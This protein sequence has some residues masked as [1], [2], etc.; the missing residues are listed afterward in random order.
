MP[1]TFRTTRPEPMKRPYEGWDQF[2]EMVKTRLLDNGVDWFWTDE[3][4]GG[5]EPRF[6]HNLYT[7]MKEVQEAYDNRRS[8]NCARGG[9]SGCQR[10]GYPWMGDVHYDRKMMIANLCNG[11]SG[12]PHSTHD[13]SGASLNNLKEETYLNGVKCNLFNPLSQCNAWVRWN[14]KSHRPWDWSPEAEQVF[15]KFLDLHYQLVPYYYTT[16]WQSHQRALPAWRALVL[17]YPDD[18]TAYSSDEVLIGDWL[19]MA[20]LYAEPARP[21]YLPQGKWY[22]LFDGASHFTGPTIL[23]GVQPPQDEYP[24]FI[25]AGAIIPLAPTMRY[26]DEKP[27]DPLTWL[28]YPLD[29]GTSTYTLYEDDGI[30]RDYEKGDTCTTTVECES[31]ESQVRIVVGERNG[32]FKP[33]KRALILSVFQPAQPQQ[34][35]LNGKPLRQFETREQLDGSGEGWGYFQDTITGVKR[36][37]VKTVDEGRPCRVSIARSAA[38][39]AGEAPKR[40]PVF[41]NAYSKRYDKIKDIPTKVSFVKEDRT[42]SGSWKGTYGKEGYLIACGGKKNPERAEI[43]VKGVLVPVR[44]AD[45]R[46][47]QLETGADR[48]AAR[49]QGAE[50]TVEILSETPEPRAITLYLLDWDGNTDPLKARAT[51][52]NA[53]NP[54]TDCVYDS[55]TVESFGNGLY[56]TYEVSGSVTFKL[57]RIK[58]STAVVSGVFVD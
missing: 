1:G 8:F 41:D 33:A 22:Y 16:A 15:R 44:T 3:T 26:V 19:L 20:A 10:F 17:D 13:M 34:V 11:L 14:K 57:Y 37:F 4:D 55:R 52:V 27:V 38:S 30:T 6:K 18:Q 36:V 47:L 43:Q 24:I 5:F 25:K 45:V 42:T 46:A 49:Y 2:K 9:Y 53:V 50:V 28:I 51:R 48:T 32:R 31:N 40:T 56:L 29:S 21:V 39:A 35:E 7:A 54:L 12:F 23:S 58:G